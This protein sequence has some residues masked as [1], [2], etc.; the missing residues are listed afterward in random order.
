MG[1]YRYR[2]TV[3][4]LAD[5]AGSEEIKQDSLVFEVKNHDEILSLARKVA[6]RRQMVRT[7]PRRS[8]SE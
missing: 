1:K 7:L 6:E 2:V 4:K 8:S 5:D 3:E